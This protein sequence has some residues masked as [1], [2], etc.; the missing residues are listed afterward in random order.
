M[1]AAATRIPRLASRYLMAGLPGLHWLHATNA[2]SAPLFTSRP[3]KWSR[4]SS[5]SNEAAQRRPR[6][7]SVLLR[8]AAR[9]DAGAAE[10]PAVRAASPGESRPATRAV[11]AT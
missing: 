1:H 4:R 6:I 10:A 9:L 8:K 2:A 5:K 3:E 11:A 7:R